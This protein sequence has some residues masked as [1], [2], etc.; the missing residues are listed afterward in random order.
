VKRRWQRLQRVRAQTKLAERHR[1]PAAYGGRC[2][3]RC[4]SEHRASV[5]DS[6]RYQGR[7]GWV[8]VGGTSLAAPL[9]ASVYAL[10][11]NGTSTVD[12]SYPYSHTSALH[13]V[14]SGSNGSCGGSYHCTAQTGYEGP[15]GGGTP[16]G[17]TAF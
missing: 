5:Y 15:T 4:R 12:G 3:S 2:C 8:Q 17:T 6:I 13:D 10:A 1:L 11:G 16:I 14:A 7:L 9:I